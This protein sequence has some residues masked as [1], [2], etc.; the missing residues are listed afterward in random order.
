M[1]K[2]VLIL[3]VGN[4]LLCDEGF[5][6]KAIEFLRS[7]Y[8]FPG[9]VT[10][11][12]GGTLGMLLIPDMQAADLV[13]VLDV[14]RCGGT[15]GTFYLLSGDDLRKSIGFK[16]STHQT[17]LADILVYCDLNGHAPETVIIGM[18]PFDMESFT[19]HISMEAE[20]LLP[21]F[22]RKTVDYLRQSGIPAESVSRSS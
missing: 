6:V 16:D 18:E 13:V 1:D 15:P 10:L 19:P 22:C 11:A 14:V 21:E 3:G 5:G 2:K 17:D 20:R 12:D 4:I 7:A 9:N 8:S